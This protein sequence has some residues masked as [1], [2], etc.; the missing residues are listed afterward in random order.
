MFLID[1]WSRGIPPEY[2]ILEIEE[3]IDSGK[4]ELI[5]IPKGYLST[6]LI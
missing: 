4:T 3:G 1:F 6:F 5:Q 2:R